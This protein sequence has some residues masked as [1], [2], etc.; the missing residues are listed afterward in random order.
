MFPGDREGIG[1]KFITLLIE[2]VL[3]LSNRYPRTGK[4]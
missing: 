4:K 3:Y 2:T 1:N